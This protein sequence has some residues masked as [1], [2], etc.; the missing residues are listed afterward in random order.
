MPQPPGF[1]PPS[2]PPPGYG[3]PPP[4]GPPPG[5]G[6]PPPSGPPPGYGPPPPYS[7]PPPYGSRPPYGGPAPGTYSAGPQGLPPLPPPGYYGRPYPPPRSGGSGAIGAVFAV[8][9]VFAVVG[10][11]VAYATMGSGDHHPSSVAYATTQPSYTYTPPP[12][13]TAAVTS[14][15]PVAAARTTPR[16]TAATP[17]T[18]KPAGPQPVDATVDNPLFRHDDTGLANIS[19]DYPQWAPNVVAAQ[20]CFRA[21]ASCLDRMWGALLAHEDLPF[22]SPQ[23]SVTQHAVNSPCGTQSRPVAFYCSANHT[24]Y[25]PLDSILTNEDPNDAAVFLAIFGH[26]YGHHAQSL[27]GI[28]GHESR[29]VY[30]AGPNTAHGLELSRRLELEANCF[31]G[32]YI[33]SSAYVG[34]LTPDQ[35]TEVLTDN[36]HS[37]DQPGDMRDHGTTTNNGAW[38]EY[39]VRNNRAQKCNTWNS[40]ADS[41]S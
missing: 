1:P 37:G 7:P 9:A 28:L 25:M 30:N 13:T 36:Y 22:S 12:V 6:P 40:P 26:E 16:T 4:S 41:V 29:E 14:A 33:G 38:Y 3:A 21:A 2:G 18:T 10:A 39:G 27:S 23:V 24:I 17:T 20:A 11:L 35:V 8:L 15:A 31:G 32:M 34:T 5:Y 19:C